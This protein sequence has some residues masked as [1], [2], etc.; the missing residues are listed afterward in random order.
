MCARHYAELFAYISTISFNPRNSSMRS[1]S[2]HQFASAEFEPR[3]CQTK[4]LF[5]FQVLFTALST[6]P[7]IVSVTL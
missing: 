4:T 7:S 3:A 5:Y 1:S 2:N 6:E